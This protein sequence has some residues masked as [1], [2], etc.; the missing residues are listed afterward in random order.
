[1]FYASFYWLLFSSLVS[2]NYTVLRKLFIFVKNNYI[3][4]YFKDIL[5]TKIH[6]KVLFANEAKNF[7]NCFLASLIY[8]FLVDYVTITNILR[9]SLVK[10]AEVTF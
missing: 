1:M 7:I 2:L 4:V 9:T 10:V 3:L 6:Q 5:T 8:Q